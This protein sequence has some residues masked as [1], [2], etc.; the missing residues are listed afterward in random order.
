MINA[1]P[2][3]SMKTTPLTAGLLVLL[4]FMTAGSPLQASENVSLRKIRSL[5]QNGSVVLASETGERIVSINA[6][7]RFVP[8]SIIKI[9]TA[10]I[11]RDLL[12]DT[13]RF[14]TGLYT[15]EHG[16]L[17]V[18]GFGDPF[19]VSDEIRIIARQLR[20][21]GV[22]RINRMMLDHSFFADDLT[23][24][25]LSKTGNPYDAINGALVVNFNTVHVR[26]ETSG[27]VVS[28]E[29]ETPLT[30]LA[31]AKA[32]GVP[33]GKTDRINLSASKADCNRYAGELFAAI[34]RE[35]GIMI[36]HDSI[37]E[38]VVDASWQQ[39]CLHGNTRS[40]DDMLRGLL[41][42][43][44]NFIA[45]Q[46]FLT[47]PQASD[48]ATEAT[49]RKSR[50][51]FED[52]LR[53]RL[54][55]GADALTM[56]EGSGISRDNRIT[57]NAMISILDRFKPHAGLLAPKDGHLVKSGTLTGIYNYAGY[58]RTDKGLRPFVILLNQRANH[59][60][61]ILALLMR[62]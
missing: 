52:H 34:F 22:E 58:I 23:I 50:R 46:I 44:N 7:R 12:G 55:I 41:Q 49:L 30:P 10:M 11:A 54:H 3:L 56:V 21:S 8:A 61:A 57:G 45:N 60:D 40:L 28:A 16:D 27:V 5:V 36:S 6:D 48:G 38:V 35:Q 43:S 14:S 47:V 53:T 39:R 2:Q 4:M 18:K 19:M 32:A 13:F 51:L 33:R 37:G 25:G 1:A 9:V 59:R 17:A 31:L 42:Y 29:A 62:I 24:P 20:S 26:K 15:N